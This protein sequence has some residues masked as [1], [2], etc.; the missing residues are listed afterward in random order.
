M[1]KTDVPD[2][3]ASAHIP[4]AIDRLGWMDEGVENVL[5]IASANGRPAKDL[6]IPKH[7]HRP[8]R[9]PN[10]HVAAELSPITWL[11][12]SRQLAMLYKIFLRNLEER[13]CI[14]SRTRI[15]H[16]HNLCNQ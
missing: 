8:M 7:I 10:G 5:A 4:V 3:R 11:K 16:G 15:W 1:H 14:L 2:S 12:I 13:R 6:C 9:K